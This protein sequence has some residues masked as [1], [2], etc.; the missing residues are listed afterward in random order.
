MSMTAQI[1]DALEYFLAKF[2][3]LKQFSCKIKRN[4][5]IIFF[6]QFRLVLSF[7]KLTKHRRSLHKHLKI[8]S[9]FEHRKCKQIFV[10]TELQFKEIYRNFIRTINKNCVLNKKRIQYRIKKYK[11]Q[12]TVFCKSIHTA[13]K[14]KFAKS[15]FEYGSFLLRQILS[16]P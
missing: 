12:L 2:N 1:T 4:N 5:K 8:L 11:K 9:I 15:R 13:I 10:T 16:D 14:D 3:F 7:S 6:C